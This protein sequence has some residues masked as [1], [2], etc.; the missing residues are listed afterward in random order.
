MAILLEWSMSQADDQEDISPSV[1]PMDDSSYYA[2][3]DIV[4]NLYYQSTSS[5]S[6][7]KIASLRFYTRCYYGYST[8][9]N[10]YEFRTEL[11]LY[12]RDYNEDYGCYIK[13]P[14]NKIYFNGAG[15]GSSG[16]NPHSENYNSATHIE[17]VSDSY[18]RVAYSDTFY[19]S[20]AS[21]SYTSNYVQFTINY[22]T[23]TAVTSSVDVNQHFPRMRID[24][25]KNKFNC[26]FGSNG[27]PS[28]YGSQDVFYGK[29]P[30]NPGTPLSPSNTTRAITVSFPPGKGTSSTLSSS[31][32]II[33]T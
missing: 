2:S 12:R 26:T 29:S 27:I 4:Y 11:W 9:N 6:K 3:G 23:S 30:N 10:R 18:T 8:S 31:G 1:G 32:S 19:Y 28:S 33:D 22:G 20:S 14:E 5:S 17:D 16:I 21:G 15:H 25:S 24:Y 7:I 13:I